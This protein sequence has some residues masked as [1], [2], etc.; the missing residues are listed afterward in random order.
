MI[1]SKY[2]AEATDNVVEERSGGDTLGIER[3]L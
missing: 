2:S 1:G 3:Y